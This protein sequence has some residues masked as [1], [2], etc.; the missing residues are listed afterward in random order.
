MTRASTIPLSTKN[1]VRSIFYNVFSAMVLS[2][3]YGIGWSFGFI[4]S[5]DDVGRD[6]YLTTQYLFS[7][8]IL[9][10]TILQLILYLPPCD[11][12]RRLLHRTRGYDVNEAEA[13]QGHRSIKYMVPLEQGVET[14]GLEESGQ[15]SDPNEATSQLDEKKA[16]GSLGAANRVTDDQESVTSYTNEKAVEQ[17][18]EEHEK[19]ITSL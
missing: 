6:A 11:E 18:D 4:A 5:S 14:I 1:S 3:I 10:H 2:L 17:S 12:L 19:H 16:T 7:F 13:G 9:T 15:T 8:L